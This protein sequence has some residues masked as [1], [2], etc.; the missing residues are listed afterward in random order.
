MKLSLRVFLQLS[1][2]TFRTIIQHQIP[3]IVTY[4]TLSVTDSAVLTADTILLCM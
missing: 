2:C 1:E 4:D 3:L